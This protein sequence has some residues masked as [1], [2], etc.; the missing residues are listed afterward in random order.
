MVGCDENDRM[1]E[2]EM[3]GAV[4]T[5]IDEMNDGVFLH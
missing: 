4:V 5:L 3:L 1:N 2:V